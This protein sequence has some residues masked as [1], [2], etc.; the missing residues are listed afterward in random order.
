MRIAQIAPLIEPAPPTGY[1]RTERVIVGLTEELV[2]RG[3]EVTL[4]ASGDSQTW[5]RLVSCLPTALRRAPNL[6]DTLAAE[7]AGLALVAP[8]SG[9]FDVIHTHS[10]YLACPFLPQWKAPTVDRLH[11]RLDLPELRPLFSRCPAVHLVSVSDSQRA[12]LGGLDLD[13]RATVYNGVALEH[14]P[15]KATG[16]GYLIFVGRYR[17]ST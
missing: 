5:V 9:E 3:H 12:P 7:I 15:L 2:R 4:S 6:V 1:G 11:G 16:C 8:L 14:I 13:W 10:G 17:A